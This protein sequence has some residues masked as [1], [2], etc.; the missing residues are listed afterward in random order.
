MSVLLTPPCSYWR[1]R[2]R[3]ANPVRIA[4]SIRLAPA[5]AAASLPRPAGCG[6]HPA[7]LADGAPLLLPEPSVLDV[8]RRAFAGSGPRCEP[9]VRHEEPRPCARLASP[10]ARRP[11]RALPDAY[12]CLRAATR[13]CAYS[14]PT[15]PQ[16]SPPPHVIGIDDFALRKGRVYGTIVVDLDNVGALS[17]CSLSGQRQLSRHGCRVSRRSRSWHAIA[18]R[19]MRAA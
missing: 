15:P 14:A 10:V 8:R 6:S 17:T 19:T 3:P 4:A 5:A 18:R 9:G 2:S 13:S 11:A 1:S 12:V 7:A 16:V